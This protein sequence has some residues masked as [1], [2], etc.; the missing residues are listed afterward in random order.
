ML[1]YGSYRCVGSIIV[2]GVAILKTIVISCLKIKFN[3]VYQLLPY[4]GKRLS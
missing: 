4:I 1:I 3:M 2:V